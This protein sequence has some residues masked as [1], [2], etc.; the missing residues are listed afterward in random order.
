LPHLFAIF[1]KKLQS[2]NIITVCSLYIWGWN[3]AACIIRAG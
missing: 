2:Y 1:Y 3:T